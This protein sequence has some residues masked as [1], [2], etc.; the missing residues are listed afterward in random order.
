MDLATLQQRLT[1]A[2]QARVA[3]V[4]DLMLDRYVYGDVARISPEAPIPVMVREK[5]ATMLG[6]AGIFAV[7]GPINIHEEPVKAFWLVA[8]LFAGSAGWWLVLS[9]LTGIFHERFVDGGLLRLNKISGAI[10][11]V[12]GAVVLTLVAWHGFT[13]Q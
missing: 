13:S 12:S 9:A 11:T 1:R 2:A 8:G 6:A 4:G 5:E 10:I 7:F 3:C